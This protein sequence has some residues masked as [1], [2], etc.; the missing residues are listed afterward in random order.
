[1]T[2]LWLNSCGNIRTDEI[3]ARGHNG[4]PVALDAWRVGSAD[5]WATFPSFGCQRRRKRGRARD[6]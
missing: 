5:V 1:V 2:G 4:V 3:V 6:I